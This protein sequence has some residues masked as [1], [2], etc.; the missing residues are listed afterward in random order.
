MISAPFRLLFD[1]QEPYCVPGLVLLDDQ[2]GNPCHQE[3]LRLMSVSPHRLPEGRDTSPTF[4]RRVA[5]ERVP[6]PAEYK[7]D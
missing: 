3:A 1:E 7:V 2:D 5:W 6:D 4:S